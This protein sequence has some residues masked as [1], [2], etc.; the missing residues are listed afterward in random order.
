M[1]PNDFFKAAHDEFTTSGEKHGPLVSIHEAYGA[2][3]EEVAEF[4]D[5]VR[6]KD[7]VRSWENA[8]HELIQIASIAARAAY[9]LKL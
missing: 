7:D 5:E 6:A 4:F 9:D 3:A 1:R 8:K 2:L